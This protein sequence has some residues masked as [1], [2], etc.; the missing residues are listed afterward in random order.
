MKPIEGISRKSFSRIRTGYN[1]FVAVIRLGDIHK[2][3]AE[4]HHFGESQKPHW[5]ESILSVRVSAKDI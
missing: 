2:K 1:S 4:R 5:S 3:E